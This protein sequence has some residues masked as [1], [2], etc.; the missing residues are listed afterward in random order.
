MDVINNNL[1]VMYYDNQVV[2]YIVNNPIFHEQ[3]KYIEVDCHFIRDIVMIHQIISSFVT[4]SSQLRDIFT[5]TLCRKSFSIL[6][7]KVGMT[8]SYAPAWGAY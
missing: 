1:I 8:D 6:Y 4:S 5:K 3:M 7:S 2:M